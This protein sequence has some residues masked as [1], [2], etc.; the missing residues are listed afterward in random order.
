MRFAPAFLPAFLVVLA[1]S[2]S[3]PSEPLKVYNDVPAFTLTAEDGSEFRSADK[4][5]GKVWVADFIFT[6]CTGPCPR[7]SQQMKRVQ[8]RLEGEA[9]VRFVSFTVDPVNDTPPALAAYARRYG[10]DPAR[11]TFLTGEMAALHDLARNAFKLSNVDAS[12]N[13]ATRFVLVD[14]AGRIRGYYGS[15]DPDVVGAIARDAKRLVAEP[16][17]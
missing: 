13:H 17:S 16:A 6:T 12:L 4:L 2:C 7:M 14:G 9:G 8:D 1:V 15:S 11:W 3:G 10:A 5:A